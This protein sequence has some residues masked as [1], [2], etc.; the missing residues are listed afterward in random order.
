MSNVPAF[1]L[2]GSQK[3]VA[4]QAFNAAI[5]PL[6]R[7][8]DKQNEALSSRLIKQGLGSGGGITNKLIGDVQNDQ[9][10]ILGGIASS[11]GS[12]LGQTALDQAFSANEN[13]LS[14]RFQSKFQQEGFSGQNKLAENQFGRNNLL[15]GLQLALQGNL[16][17]GAVNSLTERLFGQGSNFQSQDQL[18]AQRAAQAAGL[19]QD[20]FNQQKRTIGLEQLRQIQSNPNQFIN[21]PL[22]D[23]L[24]SI[25]QGQLSGDAPETDELK[26][27]FIDNPLQELLAREDVLRAF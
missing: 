18:D 24:F 25:L 13:A 15:T 6:Q 7:Q 20:E 8:F 2:P 5:T 19:T 4:S 10:S 21:D 16:Q 12:Q 26:E 11:I 22:R 14:R 1:N 27:L 9:N 17:G 3:E 23:R